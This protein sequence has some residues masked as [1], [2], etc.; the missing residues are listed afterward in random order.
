MGENLAFVRFYE[1]NALFTF[2]DCSGR[3]RFSCNRKQEI[4]RLIPIISR[5]V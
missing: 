1:K 4:R 2:A 5:V 3:L